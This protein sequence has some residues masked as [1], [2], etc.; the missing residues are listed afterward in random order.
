MKVSLKDIYCEFFMLG[1]QLLGGGY[2]IVPLMRHRLTEQ[3]S[4]ISE[5]ELVDFYAL[6]QSVPGVIAANI[7]TFVGYKLRGKLGAF[8]SLMGI[9]TSPVISILI[10]ASVVDVLLQLKFVQ[11]LF[12]GVGIAVI[13]LMYLTVKEMWAKSLVDIPAWILFFIAFFASYIFKIS[14][15][16]I[17]IFAMIYGIAVQKLR[18]KT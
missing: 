7:S 14:P 15:V 3:K 13:I 1:M 2:V 5:E 9:I 10:I 12:W 8:V 6:S 4:W 17:I 16:H 11:T 18:R